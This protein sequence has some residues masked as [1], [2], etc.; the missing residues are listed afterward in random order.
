MQLVVMMM[1]V[2]GKVVRTWHW[3]WW[4]SRVPRL[5]V[6]GGLGTVGYL[7]LQ[8]GWVLVGRVRVEGS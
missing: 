6:H 3:G 4:W 5:Q 7:V 2:M 8:V 1:V